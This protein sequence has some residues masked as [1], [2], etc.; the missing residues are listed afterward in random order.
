[1]VSSGSGAMFSIVSPASSV[2]VSILAPSMLSKNFESVL[3][4]F[5]NEL[6]GSDSNGRRGLSALCNLIKAYE[7]AGCPFLTSC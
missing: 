5:S 4:R 3:L 2:L 7:R 6:P 1:M